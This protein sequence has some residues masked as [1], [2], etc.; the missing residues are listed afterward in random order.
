MRKQIIIA[1]WKMNPRTAKET[2]NIFERIKNASKKYQRVEVVVTPPHIYLP[3]IKAGSR[4][5]LGAQDIFFKDEG[6]FTGEISAGMLKDSGVSYVLIGHSERRELGETLETVRKKIYQA[7]SKGFR[8][9]LCVGEKEKNQEAFPVMVKE[10]IISALKGVPRRLASK[11]IIAYEPVWA[12][13]SHSGGK[14]DTPQNFF[15]MSIYIRRI[16]LDIWGKNAA[17]RIPIIYGGSV[18]SKNV[19]G[20]LDVKGASGVLVGKASLNP[21]EFI[22]I[23]EIADKK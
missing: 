13:S 7:A 5:K 22:K 15:E 2:K 23:L 3:L 18:N 16:L 8:A 12:I 10:E 14:S 4:I 11:T 6:P 9:V 19:K 17:L 1:N 21:A 20:F